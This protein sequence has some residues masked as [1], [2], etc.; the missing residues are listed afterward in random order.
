MRLQPAQT[1]D[2]HNGGNR[3]LN[4]ASPPAAA[5]MA[6]PW[7][8]RT[9]GV[10]CCHRFTAGPEYAEARLN[11]QALPCGIAGPSVGLAALRHF[12]FLDIALLELL[13]QRLLF[14]QTDRKSPHDR[15]N[16]EV[17]DDGHRDEND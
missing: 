2:T 7:E 1:V 17:A 11:G 12:G 14:L 16:E 5:G 4:R 3:N 15:G 9:T 6:P 10:L 8:W 13:A